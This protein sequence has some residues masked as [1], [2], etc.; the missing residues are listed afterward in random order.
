MMYSEQKKI[1]KLQPILNMIKPTKTKKDWAAEEIT[2]INARA[3]E[4]RELRKRSNS[5]LPQEQNDKNY[6]A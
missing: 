4:F 6:Y 2:K 3:K 5:Q 1:D